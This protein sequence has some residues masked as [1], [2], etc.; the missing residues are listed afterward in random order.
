MGRKLLICLA[1]L[2]SI[3]RA[4]AQPSPDEMRTLENR[5]ADNRTVIGVSNSLLAAGAEAIRYGRYDDGIRLTLMGLERPGTSD[6]NR[7]AGL[8]NLCAAH[9]AKNEP[10]IAIDYCN[11]SLEINDQN[12][13]ALSNRSYSYWLKDMYAEAT[14]DLEAATALNPR[15]RQIA[16]IRG[17]LNEATLNPRIIM[18]D[19]Q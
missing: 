12:W 1:V 2:V 16:Q 7:S 15:A 3:G 11:Q 8:S 5:Q 9:A 13:R 17:M 4:D 18:E 6:T 19:H 14:V 10:D